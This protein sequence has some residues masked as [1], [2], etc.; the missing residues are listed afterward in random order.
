MCDVCGVEPEMIMHMFC[1]CLKLRQ[2]LEKLLKV[3]TMK[4]NLVWDDNDVWEMFLLFGEWR[5]S[6]VKNEVLCRFLLSHARCAI[7]I[8]RNIA[9]YEKK[10]VTIWPIFK[11]L[12]K[13]QIRYN[14]M[15]SAADFTLLPLG[16]NS[17]VSL[18]GEGNLIWDWGG[19]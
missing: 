2:F 5:R 4:L 7:K 10:I 13:R 12:V 3:L 11:A 16:D 14:V 17:L 8:R 15:H 9:H 6:R 19:V 1:E 18:D